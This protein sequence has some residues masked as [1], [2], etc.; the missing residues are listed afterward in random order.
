MKERLLPGLRNRLFQALARSLP[1]ATTVRA[2]LHR[3]RGVK[4]GRNVWIGYN[5]IIETSRPNL[6]QIK[7]NA[8]ISI[9]AILIAHFREIEGITIEQDVFIGPGAIVLP[10]VIIGRGAVI[11]AGSVVTSSIAPNIV[12]QGNPARAIATCG[13]SLSK[14]TLGQFYSS[15]KPI[16]ASVPGQT[17]RT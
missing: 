3:W 2:R 1:G 14:A 15:L 6:I 13:V 12:A 17:T 7:D 11:T 16:K 10:G 5:T 9:G 4:I 8:V